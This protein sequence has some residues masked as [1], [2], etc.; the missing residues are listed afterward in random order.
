[1]GAKEHPNTK[2]NLLLLLREQE[3]S[4][5]AWRREW[6]IIGILTIIPI[7]LILWVSGIILAITPIIGI[8]IIVYMTK[9]LGQ[10]EEDRLPAAR[11]AL[12]KHGSRKG[13]M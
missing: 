3:S 13:A 7:F 1:M 5:L 4:A 8:L 6:P 10:F 9:R 12:Q 11:K 2:I